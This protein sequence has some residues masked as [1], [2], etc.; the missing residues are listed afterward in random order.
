MGSIDLLPATTYSP[1]PPEQAC[2]RRRSLNTIMEDDEESARGSTLDVRRGRERSPKLQLANWLSPLSEHFPTPRG[3]HFMSAP[4]PQS[5]TSSEDE[6]VSPTASSAPWTRDSYTTDATEFDDLYDVSSDEDSRRKNSIRRNGSARRANKSNRSS[7]DSGEGRATRNALPALLIPSGGDPWPGVAAFKLMTSPSSVPPTPPPKVPM[8]PAI[9][10]YLQSQEVPSCS[11]PPSLDGSLSSDQMAALSAPPTPNI[12]NDEEDGDHWGGGVQ[13]QPAAMAT[14]QAL[15]GGD[16]LFEQQTEQVIEL[17]HVSPETSPVHEMQQRPPPLTTNIHRNNSVVLSPEQQRCMIGLTRLEI[18]SPG[19][20]FSALSPGARHTWHLVACTP[21]SAKCP[22]STTAEH[23]YKTP[24]SSNEPVE[25][26]LE[27]PDMSETMSDGLPTARPNL[28]QLHPEMTIRPELRHESSDKTMTGIK[29]PKLFEGENVIPDEILTDNTPNYTEKLNDGAVVNL[30]RTWM[31]LAAQSS[32]L[33]ELI[34][35]TED[36][37]DEVALLQRAA[38]T[39]SQKE[40]IETE[41]APRKTVRFSEV[42]STSTN[43]ACPLPKFDRQESAYLRAFKAYIAR[44][45]YRDT[46]VHRIPRFEAVQSLRVNFS[47]A[48]RA[49]LLSKYQLSVVPLSAKRRMSANVARGDEITPEDPEKLKRDKEYEALQQMIPATWNVKAIKLL[50]GG[51]LIAAPVA[52]RLARLSSMGPKLD[53]T[54]RDRARILDLGGQATCDWAW[55]CALEYPNTKVYTVTTKALR[56]LSNS[57]IRGPKN[58]RQVAVDRLVKLPFGDNQFDLISAREI[59]TVLRE[60]APNGQ[61]EWEACLKECMRVLKP[62]GYLEFS[63]MDSDVVN[64]GPLGLAK[65]VEFGFNLK[66]LGYDPC[67]TKLWLG[68]I[69]AAGFVNVKRAWL[70]LPMGAKIEEKVVNRDSLGVEVKLELEAMVSG[71]TE[72]AASVCGIVG[73]W[74]WEKWLLRCQVQ[75]VGSEGKLEGVQD[76]IEEGRACGAGWRVVSGWARKPIGKN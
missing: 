75:T 8:S 7:D 12:G 60:Q 43:I 30:D 66:T 70:F 46:F 61:D 33:A 36:R 16:D 72:N 3:N 40:A 53:G 27:V 58:H 2:R 17:T 31:W 67:P 41:S 64:A 25:R 32:Y 20:F 50:N 22:S 44:S 15:S 73:G 6:S 38:S 68:R 9:F 56:Q 28:S 13:L 19:G 45:R 63:I 62:G 49:Q 65:S 26:I 57:N 69:R 76:I 54:P 4:I 5:E 21:E 37:D 35:P 55:H 11:A 24:W 74:A 23:F 51:R 1:P 48:H 34:N 14:L 42:V 52:K 59:Y 18:P 71:S 29:S 47:D 39:K 10:S